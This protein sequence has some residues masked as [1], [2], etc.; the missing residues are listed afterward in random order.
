MYAFSSF[1]H[2]TE[3]TLIEMKLSCNTKLCGYL[4]NNSEVKH[5][6]GQTMLHSE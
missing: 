6:N 2:Y 3:L 5:V 1:P 4:F